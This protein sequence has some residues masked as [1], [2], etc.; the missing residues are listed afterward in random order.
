MLAFTE[1]VACDGYVKVAGGDMTAEVV[2]NFKEHMADAAGLKQALGAIDLGRGDAA[3]INKGLEAVPALL[4]HGGK[5]GFRN[6]AVPVLVVIVTDGKTFTPE[7]RPDAVD[8]ALE[9]LA[10]SGAVSIT[11][12]PSGRHTE[13]YRRQEARKSPVG[14][15][16]PSLHWCCWLVWCEL[17]SYCVVG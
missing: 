17:V 7:N 11:H 3:L 2:F 4:Q 5:T 12:L 9:R 6:Y 15:L 8:A 16:L 10:D 13:G 14:S 1:D